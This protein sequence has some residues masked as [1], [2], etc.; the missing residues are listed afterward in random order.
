MLIIYIMS[1]KLLCTLI[2]FSLV[3]TSA[4]SFA[5]K[6]T[7]SS[8]NYAIKNLKKQNNILE[9]KLKTQRGRQEKQDLNFQEILQKQIQQNEQT[10][11]QFQQTLENLKKQLQAQESK[12]SED[13]SL[14][15]LVSV[16]SILA[17]GLALF[18]LFLARRKPPS[19]TPTLTP[20]LEQSEAD[21]IKLSG[22]SAQHNHAVESLKVTHGELFKGFSH[23]LN[24]LDNERKQSYER[25]QSIEKEL[26]LLLQQPVS[27]E[28]SEADRLVLNT[29]L[30]EENLNFEETLQAKSLV[31]EYQAQWRL[32]IVYWETLLAEN[33]SNT[34]ALLH[35]GYSNYKLA[36]NHRK[37]DYYLT[38]SSNTYN[39]IMQLAP[40]YF[41]DI[42]AYDDDENMGASE[43]VNDPDNV[44]IYQQI[45]QLIMKV[46]ELKNYH[47]IYNLAC[48]YAKE[49]KKEEAKDWLEQIALDSNTLHCKHLHEDKD[50]DLASIRD[51]PWFQHL[52]QA[53]CE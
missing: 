49:G 29:M 25:R 43:L 9:K 40:E 12:K 36:E 16:L 34:L 52:M 48:Q 30:E 22:Q 47:S 3:F 26:R 27:Y 11:Q 31:A 15:Y 17:L 39:K 44:V 33:E 21:I 20:R 7:L 37:D 45:E 14:L 53:S 4:P 28:A 50:K 2:I 24:K 35:V 18:S 38:N 46:D 8:L 10:T 51:L 1:I 23:K 42:N 5:R 13:S 6:P 41:E 19:E 32:A